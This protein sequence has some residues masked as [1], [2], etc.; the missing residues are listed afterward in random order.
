MVFTS[1][2]L[3]FSLS[4]MKFLIGRKIGMSQWWNDK[5]EVEA[6]TLLDCKSLFSLKLTKAEND[7]AGRLALGIARDVKI[8]ELDSKKTSQSRNFI[9][10][11]ELKGN[12]ESEG[13]QEGKK[14]NVEVLKPGDKVK[15]SGLCKG[16]GYQGVV[17]RHGFAGGPKTHGHRHVLRSAGSIGSAFPEHVQK[18]KKMAGRMGNNR[19]TVKNLKVAWVDSEK[20]VVALTGAIP[21]RKGSFIEVIKE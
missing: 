21:G 2:L 18:G 6:I 15:V 4:G 11:K 9:L 12:I 14:V 16:K 3:D 19:V 17:K 5:K 8:E 1:Y 10:I 20:S 7:A 13:Y